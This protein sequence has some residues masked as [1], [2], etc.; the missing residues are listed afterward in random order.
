MLLGAL[1]LFCGASCEQA[2]RDE[3]S[4]A[5]RIRRQAVAT[6][7]LLLENQA[8]DKD[9]RQ[10]K[11]ELEAARKLSQA[12]KGDIEELLK[13]KNT[14][15]KEQSSAQGH[16][17]RLQKEKETQASALQHSTQTNNRLSRENESLR[18]ELESVRK[19][20]AMLKKAAGAQKKPGTAAVPTPE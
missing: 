3:S 13:E 10:H 6:R 17:E 8:L 15:A 2:Q 19:E 4:P 7:D 18:K 16:I 11:K 20:L 14:L 12:Q 1:L 9:L 5:V